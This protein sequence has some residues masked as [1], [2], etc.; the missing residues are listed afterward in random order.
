MNFYLFTI[1]LCF[2]QKQQC[3]TYFVVDA[4]FEL[5]RLIMQMT[6]LVFAAVHA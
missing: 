6:S 2:I 1:F 4:L 5:Q 3:H